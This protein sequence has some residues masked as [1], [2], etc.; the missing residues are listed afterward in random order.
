MLEDNG[1]LEGAAFKHLSYTED[2]EDES[3]NKRKI[4]TLVGWNENESSCSL[5]EIESI[6]NHS[7]ISVK[8]EIIERIE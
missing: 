3:E 2:T 4:L 5:G 1:I 8:L 6:V 7:Q